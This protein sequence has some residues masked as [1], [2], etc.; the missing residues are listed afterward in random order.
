M[1][2][3]NRITYFVARG[4]SGKVTHLVR[5]IQTETTLS[6]EYFRDGI[7]HEDASAFTIA[8]DGSFSTQISEAEASRIIDEEM[9]VQSQQDPEVTI[10]NGFA[11]YF[12]DQGPMLPE[13]IPP[14][15]SICGGG[16]SVRFVFAGD[17]PTLEFLAE[18]SMQPP[19][20]G[21]IQPDGTATTLESYVDTFYVDPSLGETE[22]DGQRRMQEH[23][24]RVTAEL[25]AVG[26][27]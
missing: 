13:P 24:D 2:T 25:R 14:M 26:L 21:R 5:T 10:R 8:D 4:T 6:A 11:T 20:R 1:S 15:G 17:P 19:I 22:E 7:W 9:N 3:N 12:L 27:L 18:Q 16:W 23:N